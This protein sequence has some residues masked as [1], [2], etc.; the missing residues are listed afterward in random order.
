MTIYTIGHGTIEIE[1]Y[2]DLLRRYSIQVLVDARSQP[3][4]RYAPQF[5]R[6]TLNTSLSQ[7]NITYLDLGDQ[8][9]GRP[10]DDHYYGQDG[11]VDYDRLADAPFYRAGI[12]RLRREA[13]EYCVAIMCSE[14]DYTKC[15]RYNLITR[16]LVHDGVEVQH[17]VHC[18]DLVP[19][20]LNH[21]RSV[22]RQLALP[23]A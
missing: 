15:H 17:I 14:A 11:K 6:E 22:P 13:E 16:T 23:F 5:N 1:R 2:I 20:D 18:G 9:G 10:K 3:Y 12:A 7:A 21:F 4:S 8:L 19:T